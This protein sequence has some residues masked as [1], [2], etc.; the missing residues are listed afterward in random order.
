[1]H[2]IAVGTSKREAKIPTRLASARECKKTKRRMSPLQKAEP[3]EHDE[4]RSGGE[5]GRDDLFSNGL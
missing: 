5:R 3:D 4:H 1:M 2:E